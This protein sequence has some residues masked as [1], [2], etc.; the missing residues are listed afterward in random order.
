MVN[1]HDS[2]VVA[3]DFS[4]L[5]NLFHTFTGLFI[6]EFAVTL[7]YEWSVIWGLRP[8]RWTI[9]I[10]SLTRL[11]TL[12]TVILA[13]VEFD[14]KAPYICQ[15]LL[16]SICVC[17]SVALAAAE[18]LIV[19]RIIAIW[20]RRK[21]VAAIAIGVWL[22]NIASLI[23]TMWLLRSTNPARDSC[24]PRNAEI[25]IKLGTISTLATDIVLLLI[26]LV[27]LLRLRVQGAGTL[28]LG[29]L[30]WKQGIIWFFIATAAGALPTIFLFHDL[31]DAWRI[32]F[33]FPWMISISVA[34]TRMYRSLTDFVSGGPDT[35]P[36][37]CRAAI[38]AVGGGCAL[39]QGVGFYGSNERS[40]VPQHGRAGDLQ[41]ER[42]DFRLK[43]GAGALERVESTFVRGRRSVG[44]FRIQSRTPR[45]RLCISY[46]LG[47]GSTRW[48]YVNIVMIAVQR[49]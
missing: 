20:N 24:M 12:A 9:W 46:L 10:Y 48:K 14:S 27:G 42:I 22:T 4:A 45:K 30:L 15:A 44:Q 1:F 29:Q 18:L 32:M 8:Y 41:T 43:R 28:S 31:N 6:W 21:V 40:W 16:T 47:T 25:S 11:A 19:L 5:F 34:A 39:D 7:N 17:D 37:P 13:V 2:T 38:S 26:M 23:H 36:K 3:N 35:Y 33:Q 49:K